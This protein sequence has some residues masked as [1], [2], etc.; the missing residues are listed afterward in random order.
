MGIELNWD[1]STIYKENDEVNKKYTMTIT[2]EI[3]ADENGLTEYD[4]IPDS[5]LTTIMS[6]KMPDNHKKIEVSVVENILECYE[7]NNKGELQQVNKKET[8]QGW[9]KL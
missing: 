6:E 4:V 5:D 2:F 9:R 3:E 8:N 7:P 1:N